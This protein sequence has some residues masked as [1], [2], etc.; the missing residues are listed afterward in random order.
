MLSLQEVLQSSIKH[1][2]EILQARAGIDAR[3]GAVTAAKGVFDLELNQDSYARAAGFYDGKIVDTR[4]QKR[5]EGTNTQVYGGYRIADGNF[6]IYEDKL[7]T[8]NDGEFSLGAIFS[9]LRDRAID[10][11]R[12][13]LSQR[14]LELKASTLDL[15]LT[16]V[17]VQHEA[18]QAYADWLAAGQIVN[19]RRDLLEIAQKRQSGLSQRAARGDVANIF[20]TENQQYLLARQTQLNDAERDFITTANRLSL[21]WR[22][23][24]GQPV[25]PVAT[26]LPKRFPIT[27]SPLGEHAEED[28]MQRLRARPEFDILDT[29]IEQ[30]KNRLALG[31]NRLLPRVNLGVETARDY[32]DGSPTR[33]ETE[34][35]VKLNISIPL[36]QRAGRGI[37][38]Q[39]N[40]KLK[41]LDYQRRLL[42]DRIHAEIK[43]IV[44]EINLAEQNV[45]LT[46][47][48]VKV[49]NIMQRAE[50]ERFTSGAS[51]FFVVNLREDNVGNARI[52][53]TQSQLK[54]FKSVANYYAATANL[55]KLGIEDKR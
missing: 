25:T 18:M 12:F 38:A 50:Q 16:K 31:E 41:E 19:V 22:D 5:I 46:E 34:A 23:A 14:E 2:P 44:A 52:K 36:Q 17:S 53:Q 40:A 45:A 30:E 51:D 27:H 6:P 1:Y 9:L 48:E 26:L 54:L 11:D 7:F 55:A 37:V 4:I 10:E 47:S 21:Y 24:Q 39:A 29:S 28:A 13:S 32:G 49:A 3:R 33:D 43:N 42:N 20:V 15:L 35:L 8:N